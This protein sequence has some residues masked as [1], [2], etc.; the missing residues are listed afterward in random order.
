MMMMIIIKFTE[1][2]TGDL[3]QLNEKI[4]AKQDEIQGGP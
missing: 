1:K 4:D 2:F 3:N